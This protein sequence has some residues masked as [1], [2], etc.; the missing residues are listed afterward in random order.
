ME[1]VQL[2]KQVFLVA[3]NLTGR[4]ELVVVRQHVF[5]HE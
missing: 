5:T 4:G 3:V 2:V 1:P